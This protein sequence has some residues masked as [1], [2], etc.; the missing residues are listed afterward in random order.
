MKEKL[1]ES[2]KTFLLITGML[3]V[4]FYCFLTYHRVFTAYFT[5]KMFFVYINRQ[6]EANLDILF[7][8][9]LSPVIVYALYYTLSKIIKEYKE[10]LKK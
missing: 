1:K 4:G 10:N 8:C 7:L 2:I 6:G 3:S 9:V 5:K